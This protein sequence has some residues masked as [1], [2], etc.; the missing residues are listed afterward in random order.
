MVFHILFISLF[1]SKPRLTG[2]HNKTPLY[3]VTDASQKL[4][5][6]TK[7]QIIIPLPS[8]LLVPFEK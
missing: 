7:L 8:V 3:L 2:M 1:Q 6:E 5:R 4:T